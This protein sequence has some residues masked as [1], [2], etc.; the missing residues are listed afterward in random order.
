MIKEKKEGH[1]KSISGKSG[2]ECKRGVIMRN[3]GK[4]ERKMSI[5]EE[6]VKNRNV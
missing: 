5:R 4:S 3:R 2:I 1:R 6:N